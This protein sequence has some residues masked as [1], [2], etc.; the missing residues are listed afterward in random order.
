MALNAEEGGGAAAVVPPP[1]PPAPALKLTVFPVTFSPAEILLPAEDHPHLKPGD[2]VQLRQV[3]AASSSDKD[4]KEDPSPSSSSP[5][6]LLQVGP[7]SLVGGGGGG[8]GGEQSKLKVHKHNVYVAKSIADTFGFKNFKNI[9]IKQVPRESVSLDSVELTFRE[10]YLGRSEMWRI[11]AQLVGS[12]V[13]I[14]KKVDLCAGVVRCQV[15]E[16]WGNVSGGKHFFPNSNATLKY[17]LLYLN[18]QGRE[19][20]LRRHHRGHQDRFPLSH[21]HG[22][23]IHTDELGD[24][25][26]GRERCAEAKF[27]VFGT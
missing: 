5:K 25:G 2:V 19:T 16:M 18:F 26:R 14:N 11:K 21:R 17:I 6:L 9:H 3:S 4:G 15:Q 1:P 20:V 13:Y 24:L 12:I 8:G 27:S 23:P 7:D 10:Q 22:L